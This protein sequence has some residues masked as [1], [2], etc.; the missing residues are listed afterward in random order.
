MTS[1]LRKRVL[2][3]LL[4]VALV[5]ALLVFGNWIVIFLLVTGLS[6]GLI[7][8]YTQMTLSLGDRQEKKYALL[9]MTW[10][11]CCFELLF[12]RAE[13]VLVI[14]SFLVL[15]GYFLL[16]ASRHVG[17]DLV[18]HFQE[19]ALSFFGLI[20]LVFLPFYFRKIYELPHGLEWSLVFLLINWAGDT[21]AYFAG[22]RFG[23]TK[24]YPEMSPNKTREG[25]WVGLAAGVF[26]VFIFKITFFSGLSFGVAL[27]LSLVVG[28]VAQVGDFCESFLKRS[29]HLKDSGDLLPGHGG[30]LDRFDGVVFSL[31]VMYAGIRIFT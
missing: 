6:L 28:G 24:L 3:G 2:T 18:Q 15:F 1:E 20:Y 27:L 23:R 16:S 8:E 4:G 10:L 7:H 12:P 29:F 21:G 11:L 19:L 31:P 25:A 13:D 5:L 17:T 30:L 26:A 9:A 14:L 22:K